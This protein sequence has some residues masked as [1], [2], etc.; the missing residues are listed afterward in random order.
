MNRYLLC[1]KANSSRIIE[2]VPLRLRQMSLIYEWLDLLLPCPS[3]P[4][5]YPS[6]RLLIALLHGKLKFKWDSVARRQTIFVRQITPRT[7]LK[8]NTTT[9]K[10]GMKWKFS[11][12]RPYRLPE[13]LVWAR[14]LISASLSVLVPVDIT[15][16]AGT[17]CSSKS[18]VVYNRERNGFRAQL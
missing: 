18:L 15:D 17:N 1:F 16:D 8:T 10:T 3:M 11:I 6:P 5:T 9:V 2:W 12:T 4:Y 13:V 14:R 7:F